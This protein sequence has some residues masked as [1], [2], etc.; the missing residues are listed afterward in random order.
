MIKKQIPAPTKR[1]VL[2][3]YVKDLNNA[4]CYVC[5]VSVYP[6]DFEFGH[7]IAEA[8]GG[9]IHV[10]NLRPICAKCNKSM[11]KR[12]LDEYRKACHYECPY[13][14]KTGELKYVECNKEYDDIVNRIR[15]IINGEDKY[16]DFFTIITPLYELDNTVIKIDKIMCEGLLC[17]KILCDDNETN[18]FRKRTIYE[19][20]NNLVSE[21]C[22]NMFIFERNVDKKDD[23]YY[24]HD[25]QLHEFIYKLYTNVYN[26]IKFDNKQHTIG[27]YINVVK[28]IVY[29]Y[30]LVKLKV[31]MFC[32]SENNDKWKR[33]M[34]GIFDIL[35]YISK[36]VNILDKITYAKCVSYFIMQCEW[37]L[38]SREEIP[39]ELYYPDKLFDEF[40]QHIIQF[41][42][43]NGDDSLEHILFYFTP[44][45]RIIY[46]ED[47]QY[48][49][50]HI[51]M[52][53]IE[54]IRNPF[55]EI[56]K[57]YFDELLEK[58]IEIRNDGFGDIS[59]IQIHREKI[60]DKINL[61]K[62]KF[63]RVM[64]TTHK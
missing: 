20:L 58:D 41:N 33:L 56:V 35:W 13:N 32:T 23:K 31:K 9:T 48:T 34:N 2:R 7:I 37:Y 60:E 4:K 61:Q 8:C 59:P 47:S 46:N 11:G 10:D 24:I 52:G 25:E 28:N 1:A 40:K 22:Y 64:S 44:L 18:I 42:L 5:S 63:E 49:P 39:D 55:E 38:M 53:I 62:I 19:D 43:Y 26:L 16:I 12:N 54:L 45:K 3:R 36:Y 50:E 29:L 15:F 57:Y 14:E 6:T 21:F 27:T 51:M 17:S 30:Q